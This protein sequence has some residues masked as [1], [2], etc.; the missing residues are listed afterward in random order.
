MYDMPHVR[1]A[2]DRFWLAIRTALGAG[3]DHLTRSEDVWGQWLSPDLLMS[4]TCGLPYRARLHDEVNLIGTPHY[5]LPGCPPG[6]FN[7]VLVVRADADATCLTDLNR[8]TL[9]FNE[10][11]SQSGWAAPLAHFKAHGIAFKT[12]PQTGA[13]AA[14]ARAVVDGN[15]D[16]A[17]LDALTW[18]MLTRQSPDITRQLKVIDRTAPTPGLPYITSKHCDPVPIARAIDLA[19]AT[20]GQADRDT[21]QIRDLIRIPASD[22]LAMPIPPL[23]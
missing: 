5:G 13:H 1:A 6:Y 21:L 19:I 11:L 23:A 18:A 8:P 4:Q 14:S 16:V 9:A 7:S 10:H 20:L 15:G 22:Y 17:A 12:G 3:P 2:N